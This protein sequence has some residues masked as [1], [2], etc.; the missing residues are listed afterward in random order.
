MSLLE[1]PMTHSD[2]RLVKHEFTEF[3]IDH[4]PSLALRHPNQFGRFAACFSSGAALP[5]SPPIAT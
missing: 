5:V 1:S 4:K 2:R 3:C